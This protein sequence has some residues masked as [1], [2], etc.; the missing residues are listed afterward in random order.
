MN[1]SPVINAV[2]REM[3]KSG[4]QRERK[5]LAALNQQHHKKKVFYNVR[6]VKWNL[7]FR[8]LRNSE[9]NLFRWQSRES[10]KG[11]FFDIPIFMGAAMNLLEAA[12][13]KL[14]ATFMYSSA[15]QSIFALRSVTSQRNVSTIGL[16][17]IIYVWR[18]SF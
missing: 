9:R 13:E 4:S 2:L 8:S 11:N 5:L 16:S 12:R 10:P 3:R 7:K 18:K 1:F 17:V 6:N 14:G 15:L